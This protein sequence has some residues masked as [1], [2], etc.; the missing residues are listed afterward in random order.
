M[1][2]DMARKFITV[3]FNFSSQW[4]IEPGDADHVSMSGTTC[5][6]EQI[7]NNYDYTF[8][9]KADAR[10]MDDVSTTETEYSYSYPVQS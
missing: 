10:F 8:T 5:G 3:T 7:C 9:I 6:G 1:L 2:S 4:R